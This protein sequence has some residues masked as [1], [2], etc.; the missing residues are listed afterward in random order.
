[1]PKLDPIARD[2]VAAALELHRRRLWREVPADAS[3]LIRVPGEDA[4]LVATIMGHLGSDYGL[5]LARG[6][7]AFAQTLAMSTAVGD[8]PPAA[9][10]RISMLS[11]TVEPLSGIPID[12]RGLLNDAGFQVLH[13]GL[14]PSAFVKP[15]HRRGRLPNREERR[16][17]LASVHAV[18][19]VHAVGDFQPRPLD[20][21]RRRI[22][23]IVVEGEGRD[24]HVSSHVVPWPTATAASKTPAVAAFGTIDRG[25]PRLDERWLA[26]W[27]PTLISLEDGDDAPS[28]VL[29]IVVDEA[30]GRV[31]GAEPFSSGDVAQAA[32]AL[33]KLF[34][35]ETPDRRLGLPR[36]IAFAAEDLRD[37]L[38]DA[39][40]RL[41]IAAS[42][43]PEP[44]ALLAA[45][46]SLEAKF[47]EIARE[48]A[49][50]QRSVERMPT[51]LHEWKEADRVFLERLLLDVCG[52][53]PPP[54]RAL[55]RFFGSHAIGEEV[56]NELHRLLPMAGFM[57]WFFADYRATVKSPT[58]FER[59]LRRR[60]TTPLERILIEARISA[61]FSF[62]RIVATAPGA[63][64]EIE[65]LLTGTRA[66]IHDRALSGCDIEGFYVLLRLVRLGEWDTCVVAGPPVKAMEFNAAMHLLEAHG[67][68]LTPEGLRR[69][70][71]LTGRLWALHLERTRHP[72]VPTFCNTDGEPLEPQTATFR[73][74]EVGT[75]QAALRARKEVD[76][77]ELAGSA[78]WLRLGGPAP[79]FGENTVLGRIELLDDR[80]VLEVNSRARLKR[81][82]QWIERIPGVRFE[83]STTHEVAGGKTPLDDR[84]KSPVTVA[85]LKPDERAALEKM[86]REANRRWLDTP[87]PIL[88]NLTPRAACATPDGRRRVAILIRT[89][90]DIVVPGGSI[91][92]PREELLREL[93]LDG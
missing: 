47:E 5:F 26:T 34:R 64:L 7:D 57:E 24:A 54:E 12:Q 14:A 23:E 67:V 60:K 69:S 27:V 74:M 72:T 46:D 8:R 53:Q 9:V 93:G 50:E 13:D 41:G 19:A 44:P 49:K 38:R 31:I 4:P 91:P 85:A 75:L 61:R 90:P 20:A 37:G 82:R 88:R 36:E 25:L 81:A 84:L 11:I 3:F 62:F 70:A 16:L 10:D 42:F 76:F 55:A 71:H 59:K 51:T 83:R 35:G 73:V 30:S 89:M 68:E 1:M 86:L 63:T 18:L 2:L 15:P 21:R 28:A 32:A 87:V 56:V 92:P 52:Q 29:F 65:D 6:E 40:H 58:Y 48:S 33:E 78:T 43:E 17:L 77:D 80:L 79:G 22:F 39:L 45:I 66:T